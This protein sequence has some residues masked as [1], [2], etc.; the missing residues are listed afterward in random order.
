RVL[1]AALASPDSFAE[2]PR[3]RAR[4]L[5]PAMVAAPALLA[6]AA[7]ALGLGAAWL[8]PLALAGSTW[9]LAP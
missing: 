3:H 6:A 7:V 9:S 5:S 8:G 1:R 2:A 4:D